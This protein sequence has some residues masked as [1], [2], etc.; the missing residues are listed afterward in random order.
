V[1]F[2]ATAGGWTLGATGT[3]IILT[4]GS[5]GFDDSANVSGTTT[6]NVNTQIGN[7]GGWRVSTGSSGRLVFA[8]TVNQGDRSSAI[9][10]T[11]GANG[12]IVF[13]NNVGITGGGTNGNRLLT[14]SGTGNLLVSGGLFDFIVATGGTGSL[15]IT[16]AGIT[17]LAGTNTYTGTTGI[18]N[19]IVVFQ[20]TAAKSSGAVTVNASGTIGLGVGGSG[21]YNETDVDNLFDS[22]LTGFTLNAASGVA[23]DTTAG[24]FIQ[25]TNLTSGRTLTKLGPN[26][27]TLT[28]SNTYSGLTTIRAGTLQIGN[29][30]T[31]GSIASNVSNAG[32]LVFARSDQVVYGGTISGAG[33]LTKAAAGSLTLSAAQ[34]YTGAT[35]ITGGSLVIGS[36]GSVNTS[37]GVTINGGELKYNSSTALTAPLTFTQGKLSGTGS[38]ATPV[39]AGANDILSP[40]NS[41]GTQP[42][43]AGLTW[44]SGGTYEWEINDATGTLGGN[45]GWDLL[46]VTGGT[47][48]LAS[49]TPGSF[50]LD[51]I[52]LSNLVS[53]S[54][55]NYTPGQQYTW[56]IVRTAAG[57]V[58]TPSG[59]AV[60]GEDLTSL[61]N[62]V[63]AS[64]ASGPVPSTIQVKVSSGGTGLDL[65][66]VPEPETLVLAGV[67]VFM[68]GWSL[69]KRRRIAAICD[70]DARA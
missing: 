4:S 27:L 15:N 29:S 21:Y 45:P 13:S 5:L 25:S 63:T 50:T 31:T 30:G 41:P 65:V 3:T 12:L 6:I 8:G 66:V 18:S 37:S 43:T 16:N 42:F 67:G 48:S 40:G 9:T 22:T 61:F 26:K 44:L 55:A 34:T 58:M 52:T 33:T 36:A 10:V 1:V 69:W 17:T 56:Q 46:D 59:T 39:I 68:A 49:L 64:W 70:P 60:G 14:I 7:G 20:R 11:T 57:G 2:S 35:T 19:G 23:I 62:L 51:L 32:A 38:I 53:G 47:L 28:G 54:M 24:D